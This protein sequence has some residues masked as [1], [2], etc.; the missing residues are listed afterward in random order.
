MY[1]SIPLFEDISIENGITDIVFRENHYN[2]KSHYSPSELEMMV[3]YWNTLIN[4]GVSES[5]YPFELFEQQYMIN[6]VYFFAFCLRE[7]YSRMKKEDIYSL[8]ER[9]IDGLHLRDPEHIKQLIK[10]AHNF[11]EKLDLD[12]LRKINVSLKNLES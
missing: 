11:I 1:S 6:V 8:K 12:Y 7:K 4:Q 2:L 5:S 3:I 10:K 9:K